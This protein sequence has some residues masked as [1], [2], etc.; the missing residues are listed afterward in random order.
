MK[1]TI[2]LLVAC[3]FTVAAIAQNYRTPETFV[4]KIPAYPTTAKNIQV[5]LDSLQKMVSEIHSAQKDYSDAQQ[6]IMSGMDQAAREQ[7]YKKLYQGVDSNK[8]KEMQKSEREDMQSLMDTAKDGVAKKMKNFDKVFGD[9]QSKYNAE[10]RKT[11]VP[12]DSAISVEMSK[13]TDKSSTETLSGLISKRTTS[14]QDIMYRYLIGDKAMFPM[15]FTSYFEY[16][17]G[18]LIPMLDRIELSQTKIFN[19][20]YTPHSSALG[21][22]EGYVSKYRMALQNLNDYREWSK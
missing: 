4:S 5:T 6:K 14:Y 13:A 10:V 17:K 22:I 3:L 16:L 20:S 15:F 2:I 7:A 18:T 1:K 8:M 21:A 11:I 19:L 9:A 12:L